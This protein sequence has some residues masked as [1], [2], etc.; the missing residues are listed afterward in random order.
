MFQFLKTF[1]TGYTNYMTR[2]GRARARSVLLMQD[3]RSLQDMGIS[4][5]LLLEGVDA[6]PWRDGEEQPLPTQYVDAA[7][8]REEK[9][10]IRELKRMSNAELSDMGISRG[11]IEAA[12]RFGR[13]DEYAPMNALPQQLSTRLKDAKTNTVT[14]PAEAANT[15]IDTPPHAPLSGGSSQQRVA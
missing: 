2:V 13:R 6:W 4:R 15:P 5:H 10:A 9:R 14:S 7:K 12:V 3:E 1:S 11:G 8:R